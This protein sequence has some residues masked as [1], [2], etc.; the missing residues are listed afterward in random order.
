MY[1]YVRSIARAV[2]ENHVDF[3]LVGAFD[4]DAA[5]EYM[6]EEGVIEDKGS[7]LTVDNDRND[8]LID[9]MG[10][11]PAKVGDL[12]SKALNPVPLTKLETVVKSYSHD[13]RPIV[14][15]LSSCIP[16]NTW[17]L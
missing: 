10:E 17:V 12:L 16:M 4:V 15:I 7:G 1:R 9:E 13:Q 3:D 6:E 14:L 8:Q 11:N 5:R 2:H